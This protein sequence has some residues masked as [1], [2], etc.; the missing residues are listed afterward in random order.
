MTDSESDAGTADSSSEPSP[1]LRP[2]ELVL[3]DGELRLAGLEL[4]MD[5][6][7]LRSST[8]RIR[9]SET[10]QYIEATLMDGMGNEFTVPVV[11]IDTQL[12]ERMH[13]RYAPYPMLRLRLTM[14][15]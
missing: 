4:K 10:K 13:G 2:S 9:T 14:E 3:F 5:F 8:E 6:M 12:L 15:N 7:E 11:T 1:P